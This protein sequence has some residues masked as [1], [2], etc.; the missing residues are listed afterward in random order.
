MVNHFEPIAIFQ[1]LALAN[2]GLLEMQL[3]AQFAWRS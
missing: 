3:L 1:T 2:R